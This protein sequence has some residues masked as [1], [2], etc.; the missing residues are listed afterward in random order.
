MVLECNAGVRCRDGKKRFW[1]FVTRPLS[2]ADRDI[3]RLGRLSV[4]LAINERWLDLFPILVDLGLGVGIGILIIHRV[5]RPFVH[6]IRAIEM[7]VVAA[8]IRRV[9]SAVREQP[10]AQLQ[11]FPMKSGGDIIPTT[12]GLIASGTEQ[13]VVAEGD[14]WWRLS[15]AR[16]HCKSFISRRG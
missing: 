3:H 1:R 9:R 16:L 10:G 12:N 15:G 13:V 5:A 7:D 6:E 14:G 11:P 8:R 2:L 4:Y